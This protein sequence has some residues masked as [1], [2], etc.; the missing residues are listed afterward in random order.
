MTQGLFFF[1]GFSPPSA[2]QDSG[3]QGGKRKVTG[4]VWIAV[5]IAFLTNGSQHARNCQTNFCQQLLNSKKL[6]ASLLPGDTYLVF[7][8]KPVLYIAPCKIDVFYVRPT[9][10]TV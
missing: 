1:S 7:S 4:S 10:S 8:C 9:Q 5:N 6:K 2:G 3:E